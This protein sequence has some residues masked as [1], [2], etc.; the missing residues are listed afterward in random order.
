DVLTTGHLT[1]AFGLRYDLQ[2]ARNKPSTSFANPMFEEPCSRCGYQGTGSFPGLP[3]V[4]Y[5]GAGTWQLRFSTWQPP[6]PATYALGAQ[7]STLL[8]A[9]YARFAD[10]LTA[11]AY[12]LNGVPT[13][14]GYNYEWVDLNGDH[15][16][17]PDEV[18]FNAPLGFWFVDPAT[19][20]NQPNQVR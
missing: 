3:E 6:V 12:T 2:Q 14:N 10:Q 13:T 19:L 11:L 16:V 1:L 7:N 4:K 18:N 20:P 15:A 5:H 9:S 8:R 17:E